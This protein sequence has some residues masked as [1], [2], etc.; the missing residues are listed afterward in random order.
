MEKGFGGGN[1]RM[2]LEINMC[3]KFYWDRSWKGEGYGG[4]W[5]VDD[6]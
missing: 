3:F 5:L 4:R 2:R 1:R 6:V